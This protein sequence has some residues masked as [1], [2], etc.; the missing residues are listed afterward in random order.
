MDSRHEKSFASVKK[1]VKEERATRWSRL[2]FLLRILISTGMR[3]ITKRNKV[4]NKDENFGFFAKIL[5]KFRV[6]GVEETK[7]GGEMS[8]KEIS[9]NFTKNWRNFGKKRNI[10]DFLKKSTPCT[11][12]WSNGSQLPYIDLKVQIWSE[13]Q[14]SISC[15]S[16]GPNWS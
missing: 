9:V 12:C 16:D 7:E 14:R 3:V 1:V 10:G 11:Y 4:M 6:S 8:T 5:V 15:A 13:L 2:C